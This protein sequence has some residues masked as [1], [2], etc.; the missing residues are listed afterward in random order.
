MARSYA[1][2]Y[3]AD[4]IPLDDKTLVVDT[5]QSGK[6]G[7]TLRA[8]PEGNRASAETLSMTNVVDST[9]C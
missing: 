3:D 9:T 4:T 6:A 2:E 1:T 5:T 8:L 7:D